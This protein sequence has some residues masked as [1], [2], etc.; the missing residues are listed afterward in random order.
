MQKRT[1]KYDPAQVAVSVDYASHDF[2]EEHVNVK[3]SL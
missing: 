3:H 1:D 2:P